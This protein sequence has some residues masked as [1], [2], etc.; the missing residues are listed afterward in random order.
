VQAPID[1]TKTPVPKL[2]AVQVLRGMAALAIALLHLEPEWRLRGSLPEG[3][4]RPFP[5]E[6]G[7]D[8][9]FVIS[10]FVMVY[11]SHALFGRPGSAR[12]FLARRFARVA[13]LYWLTTAFVLALLMWRPDLMRSALASPELVAASFLFIPWPRPDGIVQ[14]VYTL[15]WTLNYEMFFYLLFALAL[16]LRLGRRATVAFVSGLLA[17]LIGAGLLLP[18]LPQPLGFW[19]SS[20]QVEFVLGMA[21]GLARAEGLT[22]PFLARAALVAAGIGL[23]WFVGGDAV[24]RTGENTAFLFALPAACLVA[25]CGLAPGRP[26]ARG[27]DH[28]PARWHARIGESLGDASYAIYLLHPFAIRG[29]LRLID[30]LGLGAALGSVGITLAALAATTIVGLLSYRLVERPLTRLARRALE[31]RSDVSSARPGGSR[32]PAAP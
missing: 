12:D 26:A 5:L 16:A 24:A 13:P 4:I 6:A 20:I 2:V 15:G 27:R 29:T 30:G 9:F 21:L 14:P 17:L 1:E 11:A 32:D 18:G 7:V 28:S 22:L 19:T 3:W 25:A 10:G 31:R 8:V 23:F